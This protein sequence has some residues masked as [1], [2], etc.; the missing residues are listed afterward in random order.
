MKHQCRCHGVSGSC[1]VKTCWRS[2]PTF[3]EVGLI[4]KSKYEESVQAAPRSRR[5]LR[6]KEKAKRKMPI[7][8][9]ELVHINRSP[10]YC[11]PDP[12]KGI[13]G[14]RGRVC[15]KTSDGPESCNLLC[16]GRGYNTQVVRN[17]ERCH[18]KFIWCC[19]VECKTCTTM[20]DIHTCK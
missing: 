13:L 5:K 7:T 9:G 18:C 17:V 8:N 1:S 14:T 3:R 12:K 6:R 4:L 15:N 2:L 11:R 19:R 20:T 10:N 16:C